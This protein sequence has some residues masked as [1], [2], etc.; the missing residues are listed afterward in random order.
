M[1]S[2][3]GARAPPP[4]QATTRR[5]HE[6]KPRRL[7]RAGSEPALRSGALYRQ[8]GTND[9]LTPD[10]RARGSYAAARRVRSEALGAAASGRPSAS[11][12]NRCASAD[13]SNPSR[14]HAE[15]TTPP[16][17]PENPLTPPASPQRAHEASSGLK[18][19]ASASFN[20][21]ASAV[22]SPAAPSPAPSALRG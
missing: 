19:A 14:S 13:S 6:R 3:G 10:F 15:Q 8:P 20:R 1:D 22:A 2:R 17:A 4:R 11:S 21:K 12:M 16:A 18:P 7:D 9:H 5:G